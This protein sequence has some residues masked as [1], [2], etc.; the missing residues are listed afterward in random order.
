ME[1]LVRDGEVGPSTKT[2]KNSGKGFP[3]A[4][5]AAYKMH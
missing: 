1:P 4:K 5:A 3:P 2:S